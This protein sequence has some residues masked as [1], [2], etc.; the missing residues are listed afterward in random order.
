MLRAFPGGE[1]MPLTVLLA[2]P[3]PAF[4]RA[5]K[6]LLEQ[7]RFKVLADCPDGVTAV[8]M[9]AKLQPAVAILELEM[10]GL[11]G[12]EATRLISRV[13]PQTKV[14]LLTMHPEEQLVAEARE[15]GAKAFIPKLKAATWVIEAIWETCRGNTYFRRAASSPAPTHAGVTSWPTSD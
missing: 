4:R 2:D 10:Y 11:N 15:A 8:S 1:Q 12:L 13:S 7:E 5:L 14:I 6:S 9:A 3:H